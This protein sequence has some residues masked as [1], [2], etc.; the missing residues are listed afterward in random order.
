MRK[1]GRGRAASAFRGANRPHTRAVCRSPDEGAREYGRPPLAG[2]AEG[3][4]SAF[5]RHWDTESDLPTPAEAGT[6]TPRRRL[7]AGL[8]RLDG[9]T[10][11]HCRQWLAAGIL[12]ML[13]FPNGL[14]T[15]RVGPIA[16]PYGGDPCR[17]LW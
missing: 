8:Q 15:S 14:L 7:K 6:P 12:G 13:R 3:W 5:R 4:S 16:P 17:P 2:G 10:Q 1:T 9:L 11:K